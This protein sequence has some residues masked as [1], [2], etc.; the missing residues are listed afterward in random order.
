M[1]HLLIPC[2]L[3]LTKSTVTKVIS[4]ILISFH[5]VLLGFH[6]GFVLLCCVI[7]FDL[8]DRHLSLDNNSCFSKPIKC[9]ILFLGILW[10]LSCFFHQTAALANK[11]DITWFGNA[12]SF[13]VW[14]VTSHQS[15]LAG[16]K[17][18][19][20]ISKAVAMISFWICSWQNVLMVIYFSRFQS[21]CSLVKECKY[22]TRF[23]WLFLTRNLTRRQKVIGVVHMVSFN[24]GS[25]V[26]KWYNY[27]RVH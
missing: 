25:S 23:A 13:L 7:V 9:W 14:I 20:M 3:Q 8:Y 18:P 5:S 26:S 24:D 2:S 4:N 22:T 27:L 11:D 12:C 21:H 10:C 6:P 17:I 19:Q 1:D 16:L 15:P